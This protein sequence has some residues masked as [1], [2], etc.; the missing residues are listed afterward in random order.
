MSDFD[1]GG[2]RG[3]LEIHA[4][5][6]PAELSSVRHQVR[7]FVERAGGSGNLAADLELV[8]SELA[9]N[10]I[11][12]TRSPTLTVIVARTSDEWLIEVCDVADLGILDHVALPDTSQPS[13]RGLFV[14]GSIVDHMTIVEVGDSYAIRCRIAVA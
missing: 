11:E 6:D 7:G 13:G 3:A 12:H 14:V 1:A 4:T 5:A 10:V 8:V 2:P 9:T